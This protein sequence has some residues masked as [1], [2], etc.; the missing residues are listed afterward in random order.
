MRLT[1]FDEYP[2]HQHPTP[3]HIPFTSDV[4]FNDGYFC[5]A[6]AEDWY[7]VAGI[8]LHPNMNVMDGF[9]GIARKGEQRVLR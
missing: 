5:A 3:F 7:V 8:R 6:F 4:H 1:E 2:F 9:A